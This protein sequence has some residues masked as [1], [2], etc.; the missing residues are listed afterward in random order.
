MRI[1]SLFA[2]IALLLLEVGYCQATTQ[3]LR[4][5][6]QSLVSAYSL[7]KDAVL[8]AIRIVNGDSETQHIHWVIGFSTGH[9]A[10]DP[11][12]AEA[13]RRLASMLISDLAIVGDKVSIFA[14]EMEVWN[15]HNK[16]SSTVVITSQQ[17]ISAIND[18]LP[19]TP[20]QG[21]LGGHDTERAFVEITQALDNPQDA[22]IL[23]LTPTAASIAAP[24][25]RV[26]GQNHP[27]YQTALSSWLR[28][29]NTSTGA[30]VEI[31]FRVIKDQGEIIERRFE[32]LVFVP[33]RFSASQIVSGSRS[34]V[35]SQSI[36]EE[37]TATDEALSPKK[38]PP[39]QH[40]ERSETL[41]RIVALLLILVVTVVAGRFFFKNVLFWRPVTVRLNN[42][43][44]E[45]L[46]SRNEGIIL[47]GTEE[48]SSPEGW[49]L[50]PISGAPHKEFARIVPDRAGICVKTANGVTMRV[51]HIT[52]SEYKVKLE[53]HATLEFLGREPSESGLPDQEWHVRVDLT[54][55]R[56][57]G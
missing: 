28:I 12:A 44:V 22:V 39:Q 32:V 23:M 56:T 49:R 36:S 46:R 5:D 4:L 51:D 57:R 7:L 43:R 2:G 11:T 50:V 15:H 17:E 26:W 13:K 42:D 47:A 55:E 33:R 25:T 27:S 30:S 52:Y 53:E 38:H 37:L 31:P 21:T 16:P 3:R 14:W 41:M 35:K 1:A 48:V 20:R 24:G 8:D 29:T 40:S 54:V 34:A 9:F 45:I 18:L 10:K 6:E 19:R